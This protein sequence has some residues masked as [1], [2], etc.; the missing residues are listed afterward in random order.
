MISASTSRAAA[1]AARGGT[2]RPIPGAAF[3]AAF[4]AVFGPTA[5][6]GSLCG[7]FLKPFQLH[8]V[9]VAQGWT[10]FMVPLLLCG[11]CFINRIPASTLPTLGLNG[12]GR[13][14]V[15]VATVAHPLPDGTRRSGCEPRSCAGNSEF[16]INGIVPGPGLFRAEVGRSQDS[17]DF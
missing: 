14:R 12:R 11:G 6:F 16:G 13:W 4:G 3:G 17:E 8:F 1:R 7:I 9:L 2:F 10:N 5:T 15:R